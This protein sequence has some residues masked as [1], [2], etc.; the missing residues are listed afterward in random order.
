MII[1]FLKGLIIGAAIA[2]PVGPIG[3][4]CIQ[5]SLKDGFRVGFITGI[6][7]AS[8]DGLYG[9]IAAFGLTTL[10]SFLLSHQS[11]IRIIG[12]IFLIYLGI[13]T[14]FSKTQTHLSK[15]NSNHSLWH[16]YSTTFFLTL[17]NPMTI[18]SFMAVFAGL[19]LGSQ[20]ND[21]LQATLIVLGIFMG[22]AFWWF[23]LSGVIAFILHHRVSSSSMKIINWVSSVI[24][25]GF[26]LYALIMSS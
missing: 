10:S 9:F 26:G 19:G 16:S 20:H 17:T 22:S 6:G 5:R 21:Y 11:W 14:L 25:L 13:K 23:F 3:I 24:M 2:A 15:N 1:L 8:A 4:I 12:G 18:L 7:A